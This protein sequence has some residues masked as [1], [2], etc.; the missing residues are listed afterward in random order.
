[1]DDVLL[2]YL[3]V[4]DYYPKVGSYSSLGRSFMLLN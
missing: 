3:C 4:L 2:L 1:M